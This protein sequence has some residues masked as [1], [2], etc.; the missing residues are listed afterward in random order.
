MA[1]APPGSRVAVPAVRPKGPP[2]K[3]M[4]SN[5]T[6]FRS[7][8]VA[9]P[10]SEPTEADDP[11]WV[12]TEFEVFCHGGAIVTELNLVPS[13]SLELTFAETIK[14]DGIDAVEIEADLFTRKEDCLLEANDMLPDEERWP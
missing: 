11:F 6:V 12:E 1:G 8:S 13:P 14:V 3:L 5:V 7:F 9:G 2:V 4:P 10:V